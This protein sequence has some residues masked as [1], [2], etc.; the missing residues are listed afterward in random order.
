MT[1]KLPDFIICGASKTGTT[2]LHNYL[3]QH[4]SIDFGNNPGRHDNELHFFDDKLYSEKDIN[5]Y[6]DFFSGLDKENKWGDTTPAYMPAK[7]VPSRI[8]KHLKNVKLIFMFRNPI[9]RSYSQYLGRF[10][11]GKEKR[12]FY[13]AIKADAERVESGI[14]N[15][16]STSYVLR[17]IYAM[18]IENYLK[19]FPKEQM[20]FLLTEDLNDPNQKVLCS[21]LKFIGVELIKMPLRK[22]YQG[23]YSFNFKIDR[24]RKS[25]A[26][27]KY[28]YIYRLIRKITTTKNKKYKPTMDKKSK[29]FLL[30][31]YKGSNDK[32]SFIINRDLSHWV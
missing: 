30:K 13:T 17:S 32:L 11:N 1:N 27:K 12:D 24:L 25:K 29:S 22:D 26:V 8:L 4:P 19:Y 6:I 2:S 15:W 14:L 5:T 21:L 3:N 7:D 16:G 23:R 31:L 28:N 9:E 20:F 18:H 10:W